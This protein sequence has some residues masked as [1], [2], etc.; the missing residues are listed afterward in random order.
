MTDNKYFQF[1]LCALSFGQT[2]DARLEAIL[3]YSLIDKGWKL[4][5]KLSA[6][7]QRQFLA[8]ARRSQRIP[9]GCDINI[10]SHQAA[11]YDAEIIGISLGGLVSCLGRYHSLHGYVE[12]FEKTHGRDAQVR[13]KKS[14][15]FNAR[16]GNG[17]TYREFS[18]LCGIYS[19][20]GSKELA[21]VTQPRIRR[22][23]LGYRSDAIMRVELRRR[24]DRAKPLT[25]RQLRDTISRL[26]R[27]KFFA[28][29]TVARRFTYYSIRLDNEA[30]RKKVEDRHTYPAFFHA[31]Q[32]AQDRVLT[33][34]IKQRRR[35]AA[36]PA[37][38][39]PPDEQR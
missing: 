30:L 12:A 26:H 15:L 21:R 5:C 28:R 19:A 23:V 37:Q 36:K 11:L 33:E 7:Q 4:F 35:E 16:D 14:W 22:C 25:E 31:S 27:N 29:C 24:A 32:L 1:P 18:V 34:K 20:I 13:I 2:A 17:L 38:K 39:Q 8:L 10:W 6:E 9:Q 3:D